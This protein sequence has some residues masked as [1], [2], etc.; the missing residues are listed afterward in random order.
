M[1]FCIYS[2]EIKKIGDFMRKNFKLFFL[3][4]I[5]SKKINLVIFISKL[6]YKVIYT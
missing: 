1:N 3:Q 4:R 6:A 5:F 2:E